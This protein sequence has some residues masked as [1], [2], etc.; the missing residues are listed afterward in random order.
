MIYK[1]PQ[2]TD[3]NNVRI[4]ITRS[5]VT[6]RVLPRYQRDWH[7]P[8]QGLTEQLHVG[9]RSSFLFGT[10]PLQIDGQ[11]NQQSIINP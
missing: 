5:G 10:E 7:W 2:W 4:R 6:R 11:S 1:L 8:S 9:E 3:S